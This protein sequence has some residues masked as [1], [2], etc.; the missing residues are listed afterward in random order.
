VQY[1]PEADHSYS[2]NWPL[3]KDT[4]YICLADIADPEIAS[5]NWLASVIGHENV[6]AGQYYWDVDK[7]DY[8]AEPGTSGHYW[9]AKIEIEACRWQLHH[10]DDFCLSN[11]DRTILRTSIQN[12]QRTIDAWEL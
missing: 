6:H 12:Y 10:A 7:A 1:D 2:T 11:G 3:I 5:E 8:D 9:V 4:I